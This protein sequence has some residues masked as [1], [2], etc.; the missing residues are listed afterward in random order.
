MG[1]GQPKKEYLKFL[2]SEDFVQ[3]ESTEGNPDNYIVCRSNPSP[4]LENIPN[5]NNMSGMVDLR[6]E[7]FKV[8]VGADHYNLAAEAEFPEEVAFKDYNLGII[9]YFDKDIGRIKVRRD[10]IGNSSE[11]TDEQVLNIMNAIE[12]A[13][14]R[15]LLNSD[16]L[17]ISDILERMSLKGYAFKDGTLALISPDADSLKV[18]FE[19][20]KICAK[21]EGCNSVTEFNTK[22]VT[23][24]HILTLGAQ[25]LGWTSMENAA[26]SIE[27][28]LLKLSEK[29][30][31]SIRIV[32]ATYF[33]DEGYEF[34]SMM[35]AVENE[36]S[37]RHKDLGTYITRRKLIYGEDKD[38]KKNPNSIGEE[39]CLIIERR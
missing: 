26:A 16:E 34:L 35:E 5:G 19:E 37:K 18:A 22:D 31:S 25:D 27:D 20:R 9:F 17:K 7:R 23:F 39:S 24:N 14:Q 32:F 3:R 29:D 11:R 2:S 12:I 38:G 13:L 6:G 30:G 10:M 36:I 8:W 1:E 21:Y 33:N 4:Q 15:D 28:M